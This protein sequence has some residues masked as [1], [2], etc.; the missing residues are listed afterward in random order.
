MKQRF[1][2][3]LILLSLLFSC[4]PAASA[5]ATSSSLLTAGGYIKLTEDIILPSDIELTKD[6][7][8]DLNGHTISGIATPW[9]KEFVSLPYIRVPAGV[10]L[11]IKNGTL[12]NVKIGNAG[13]IPYLD[14]LTVYAPNGISLIYNYGHIETIRC[15]TMTA[16]I[17]CVDNIG[18]IDLV[19]NCE[20]IALSN[21]CPIQNSSAVAEGDPDGKNTISRIRHCRFIGS[22]KTT[23]GYGFGTGSTSGPTLIEDS[24]LLGH[25]N[26]G[27]SLSGSQFT[28]KNC[29]IINSLL[30]GGDGGLAVYNHFLK[31]YPLFEGCTFIASTGA[32][33]RFEGAHED[34]SRSYVEYADMRDC[35]FISLYDVDDLDPYLEWEMEEGLPLPDEEPLPPPSPIGLSNFTRSAVYTPGQFADLPESHWGAPSI[36]HAYEMGLMAGTDTGFEPDGIVSLA[37]AITMAAHLRSIYYADGEPFL[38]DGAWY[39]PFVNYALANGI[40]TAEYDNYNRPAKRHEFVSILAAALPPEA[41]AAINVVNDNTI[42]DIP[43]DHPNAPAIYAFYRA[44]ILTGTDAAGTFAPDLEINR[45]AAAVILTHL[46]APTL[47]VH[48]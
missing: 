33:G 7:V 11:S 22:E 32:C 13:H 31:T 9:E 34:G 2:T 29:V 14:S 4:I 42:P 16:A 37:Q 47:R 39:Q 26:G 6:T 38:S 5:T 35:K 40:L 3:I 12:K 24:V 17:R 15:C 48:L 45:A 41:V 10:S 44:G 19:D 1:F 46:A 20:M 43:S 21:Y 8:L 30:T 18:D 27:I 36:A 28:A 23:F 25:G